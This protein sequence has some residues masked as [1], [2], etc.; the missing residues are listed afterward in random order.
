MLTS[1]LP[2][3][4]WRAI[5]RVETNESRL[6]RRL[7]M[8]ARHPV[9]R[10]M[11]V[12]VSR[13]TNGWLYAILSALMLAL[14][15]IAGWRVI[16]AAGL[17]SLVC[18]SVYPLIKRCVARPRPYEADPSLEPPVRALDQYSCPSGHCMVA[19]AC[20]IPLLFVCPGAEIAIV[21]GWL[22][23]AWARVASAHHYPSDVVAGAV[24]GALASLPLALW[25]L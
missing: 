6:V 24:L 4:V 1:E 25:I 12:V 9:L 13:L 23:I 19:T 15:G 2:S 17:A 22:L 21:M 8:Q 5:R 14:R 18:L 3:P 16:L 7:A 11:A 10:R 20:G